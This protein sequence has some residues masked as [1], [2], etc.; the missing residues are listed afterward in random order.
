MQEKPEPPKDETEAGSRRAAE[1]RNRSSSRRRNASK[2]AAPAQ[3]AQAGGIGA[4]QSSA[5]HNYFSQV[6][7]HLS[8]HKRFPPQA[9]DAGHR[10]VATVSFSVDGSGNVGAV[11]ARAFVGICEPRCGIAG[12]GEARV[13][14]PRSAR[15]VGP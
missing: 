3:I 15:R 5:L 9:R 1:T 14:L 8:R 7:Q 11:F 13:A 12:D 10:G 4:G 2:K 6:A